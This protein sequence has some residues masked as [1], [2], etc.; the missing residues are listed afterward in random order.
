MQLE[1]TVQSLLR[2]TAMITQNA[3]PSNEEEGKTQ[4]RNKVLILD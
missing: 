2:D 4:K 1:L 3:T